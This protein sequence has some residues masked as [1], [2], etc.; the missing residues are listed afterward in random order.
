MQRLPGW[1]GLANEPEEGGGGG[2]T[3]VRIALTSALPRLVGGAVGLFDRDN[4]GRHKGLDKLPA[5]FD[6]LE[7]VEDVRLAKTRR[8]AAVLLPC[9]P[10]RE[11]H[12]QVGVLS[13][14]HLFSDE[15]LS[16][17]NQDGHGLELREVESQGVMVEGRV[18]PQTG[19]LDFLVGVAKP[20]GGKVLFAQEIAPTLGAEEFAQFEPLLQLIEGALAKVKA[21]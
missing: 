16:R 7:G 19:Q 4:E 13:I 5:V 18:I 10:G 3:A 6:G 12:D 14:E 20:V 8:A 15:V 2:V 9:P 11:V 1:D 17:K 21:E